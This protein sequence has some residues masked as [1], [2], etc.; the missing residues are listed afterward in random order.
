LF[1]LDPEQAHNVTFKALDWLADGSGGV[2]G[3]GS[4]PL[5]WL[6][7]PAVRD[8]VELMGLRFPNRVGLAAGLDKNARH[9]AALAQLGF[10][11]LEV[12]TVTP[13]AQPGN[14]QPRMFRLPEAK[15]IINRLGFNNDGLA[16]LVAHVQAARASDTLHGW[17]GNGKSGNSPVSNG[18]SSPILLGIN[19]GKNAST[20]IELAADD[21]ALGLKAAYPL[22]DYIAVN[23]SS[24]NTSQLRALQ[25]GDELTALLA[26]L[27]AEREALEQTHSRRVPLLVKIAPD[28]EDSAIDTI[29]R[30]LPEHGIDGVIATNTT[31]AREAVSHLKHGKEIGGL[32]GAPVREASNRVIRRLRAALS[33]QMPIIGVGGILSGADAVEKIEAG[34]SLVQLYTG[35]LYEGPALVSECARAIR[36]RKSQ[37]R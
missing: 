36:D 27:R 26:R 6:A 32:S 2:S 13:R 19:I 12:G 14:P 8:P 37:G 20:P 10:G 4:I 33:K 25:G 5:R 7:G 34:A 22:A 16:A 3:S 28:L 1:R 23:I 35:L 21:Y 24:P 18:P 31:I 29:A 15:G 11:F 17:F 9:L 30:V